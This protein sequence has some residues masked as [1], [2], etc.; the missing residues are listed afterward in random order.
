M[1]AA[2][3]PTLADLAK[4]LVNDFGKGTA[5]GGNVKEPVYRLPTGIFILDYLTLGGFPRGRATLLRGREGSG[6]SL[7]ALKAIKSFQD[8]CSGCY[9]VLTLCE[10][11]RPKLLNACYVEAEPRSYHDAFADIIGI[12]PSR[13]LKLRPES[14]E[15][16][17]DMTERVLRNE[18]IGLYVLDSV[19]ALVPQIEIE[20]SSEEWQQGLAAREVN[21]LV[22]KMQ[23]ATQ[24][25]GNKGEALTIILVNQERVNLQVKYGDNSDVPGGQGQKFLSRLTLKTWTRAVKKDKDEIPEKINVAFTIIKHTYGPARIDGEYTVVFR[26]PSG[27]PCIR[28]EN[29]E[30]RAVVIA[31]ARGLIERE[32]KK[33]SLLG[34]KYDTVEEIEAVVREDADLASGLREALIMLQGAA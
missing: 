25:R 11:K 18:L 34:N 30:K 9:C 14:A 10:C 26:E 3:K 28:E 16:T 12:D 24:S 22:R 17:I 8:R 15:Q 27:T 31:Q 23:A 20:K 33:L 7:L 2:T 32:G 5:I 21:K 1:A 19:A 4:D 13:V 6:K 29:W